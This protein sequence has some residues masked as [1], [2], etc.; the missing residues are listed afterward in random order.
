L[1]DPAI[2]LITNIDPQSPTAL[3]PSYVSAFRQ[4]A[5]F[6]QHQY[7]AIVK[8]PDAA[9]WEVYVKRKT[10]EIRERTVQLQRTQPGTSTYKK[11]N[12]D[13]HRAELQLKEDKESFRLHN[14]ARDLFLRQAIEMC[15]RC[16]EVSDSFDDDAAIRL[17]SLWFDSFDDGSLQDLVRQAIDRVA[18]RKFVFLAHQ[19][20]AR[21]SSA[22]EFP[23]QK[24]QN[25]EILQSLILRMCQEHPFH[26]LYQVYCL[27]PDA[28]ADNSGTRR[29]SSRLDTPVSHSQRATAAA[30]IFDR[31]RGD[32]H[33]RER[34]NA[35]ETL[36]NAC[37]EWAKFPIK[38]DSRYNDRKQKQGL[39]IPRGLKIL[40]IK[41]AK[42]PVLTIRTPIDPTLLY[43]DCIWIERY[44]HAFDTAGGVNLPKI[45]RCIGSDGE[46]YKQL[47][48]RSLASKL[49]VLTLFVV[50]RRRGR[51][52][53]SRRCDGTSL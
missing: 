1:F 16:L 25:Q 21:M 51:R 10:T 20:S 41:A 45:S 40:D 43:N 33:S 19:L 22:D 4:C 42:V 18:S 15:S 3:N 14:M 48:C 2:R 47:V 30:E 7:H 38:E 44:D 37:L 24:G 49:R 11:L 17:C 50:Q 5:S 53:A 27:R 12:H 36:C 32:P 23:A 46:K 8:S 13:Q 34:V 39:Q 29:H 9:R 28:S 31:L 26:S 6:A 52:L 35:I